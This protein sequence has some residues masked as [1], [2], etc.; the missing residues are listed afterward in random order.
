MQNNRFSGNDPQYVKTYNQILQ[1]IQ[2][3]LYQKDHKLP[4]ENT[5][6]KEMHVSR[7]T[8]RQALNLLKE[9][10]VIVSRKG[11]GNFIQD[12]RKR[13]TSGLEKTGNVLAKCGIDN[14]DHVS[15]KAELKQ[16]VLYTEQVFHRKFAVFLAATLTFYSN[17]KIV[18]SALSLIPMD[19]SAVNDVD[20]ENDQAVI[21]LVTKKIYSLTKMAKIDIR[22]GLDKKGLPKGHA[23]FAEETY[24]TVFEECVD[25]TG[26]TIAFN[27]YF[28]PTSAINIQLNAFS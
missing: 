1:N 11:V 21:D 20:L 2:D 17:K 18:A 15:C 27:K 6:A 13:V 28:L 9:D 19:V 4:G 14:V 23:P 16:S 10:G 25:R 22:N 26:L 8:L 24:T 5:L 12:D 7:V 3:G